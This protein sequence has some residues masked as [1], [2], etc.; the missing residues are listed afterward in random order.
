MK[1]WFITKSSDAILVNSVLLKTDYY[2][3]SEPSTTA[4][5]ADGGPL[6]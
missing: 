6:L 2:L 5:F 1:K 4:G 3:F